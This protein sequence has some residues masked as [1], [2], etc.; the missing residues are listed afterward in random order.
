MD[1]TEKTDNKWSKTTQLYLFHKSDNQ[2]GFPDKENIR[3]YRTRSELVADL[4]TSEAMVPLKEAGSMRSLRDNV[5]S[6]TA[7]D[8]VSLFCFL[9]LNIT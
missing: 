1:V 8:Q 3:N 2:I 7:I 9:K 5:Y 6:G 4:H